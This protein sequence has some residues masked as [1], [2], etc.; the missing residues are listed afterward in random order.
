[1]TFAR[2]NPFF[3]LK[4]EHDIT[5]TSN[6][7]FTIPPLHRATITLPS[8]ARVIEG[9]TIRYKTLDGAQ[10][11]KTVELQNSIDWHLPIFISQNIADGENT[12]KTIKSKKKVKTKK[13]KRKFVKIASL[14]FISFY[15]K[16]HELKI[17]TD[18]KLL[19]DFL[20]V[21][22]QRIVCDFQRDTDIGS[23]IQKAPL[24]SFFTKVRIGTHKGYYRVV[25]ELDGFYSYSVK[26]IH[27]GY[28]ITLK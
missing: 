14:P 18:D 19:R 25:V 8:T 7:D 22:P 4:D 15:E 11:T 6:E 12:Q 9:V 1:M 21:T 20:L 24:A 17:V 13:Q 5:I 27:N 28:M 23:F 16:E 3:P 26:K 10:H 2:E